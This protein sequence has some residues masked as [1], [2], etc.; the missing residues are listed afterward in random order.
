[1]P[2]AKARAFQVMAHCVHHG[3]DHNLLHEAADAQHQNIGLIDKNMELLPDRL[4]HLDIALV[5]PAMLIE[6]ILGSA[7]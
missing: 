3:P 4:W 7:C 1:M 2:H 6:H 5:D